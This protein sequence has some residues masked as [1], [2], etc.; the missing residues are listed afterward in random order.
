MT[1]QYFGPRSMSR[2]SAKGAK[3][4]ALQA[5]PFAPRWTTRWASWASLLRARLLAEQQ[6]QRAEHDH[7][8]HG[9]GQHQ[10]QHEQH[11]ADRAALVTPVHLA[12][13]RTL[14]GGT[15]Q[16]RPPV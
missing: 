14:L 6:V 9:R 3:R 5:T 1:S 7:G 8:H 11:E 4:P 16:R 13:D 12:F 10:R 15:P 2:S